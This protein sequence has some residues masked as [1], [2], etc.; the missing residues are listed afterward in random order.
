M[1][2][3]FITTIL[4]AHRHRLGLV[5]RYVDKGRAQS[6][7]QAGNLRAHRGTQ[8]GIQVGQRLVQQEYIRVAHHSASQCDTLTLAAGQRLRL[9]VQQMLQI[10]NFSYFMNLPVD[11]VLRHLLKRQSERHILVNRHM[12][13]QRVALENHRN[14][15]VLRRNVID[16]ALADI[17]ITVRDLLKTCNHTQR[18]RFTAAGRADQH[19]KFLVRDFK[20]KFRHYFNA[21]GIYLSNIL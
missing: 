15:A 5:V 6:F 1:I 21:A 10:Q 17:H 14:I 4:V 19:D 9:A 3:L 2:P 12:R 18:S 11:F 7:M 13:I 8:L 16:A 20:I